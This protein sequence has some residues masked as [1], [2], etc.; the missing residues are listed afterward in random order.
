MMSCPLAHK[1][2]GMPPLITRSH[3]LPLRQHITDD[4]LIL[5]LIQPKNPA[6]QDAAAHQP[7][8]RSSPFLPSP[9][10]HQANCLQGNHTTIQQ[11]NQYLQAQHLDRKTL[12]LIV[13]QLQND[14]ALLRY[15]LFSSVGTVAIF[16][17]SVKNSATSQLINPNPNP[18]LSPNPISTALLLPC[19]DEPRVRRSTPVGAVGPPKAKTNNS[20]NA[21]FRPT[22]N[23]QEVPPNA[24]Q[25]FTSSISEIE[26][27][28]AEEIATF[29]STTAGNH[30]EYFFLY[31]KNHQLEARNSVAITW[32]IP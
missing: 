6:H 9:L 23:T 17:I 14:F 25:N 1:F 7:A 2:C 26:K 11:F 30:S 28:S 32:K 3:A 27:I 12:Q 15:L 19:G 5:L 24:A 21:D 18:N 22:P 31:D 16:G 4:T 10:Q 8:P 13:P 29:T 20:A